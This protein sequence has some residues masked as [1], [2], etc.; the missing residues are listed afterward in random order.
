M[1]NRLQCFIPNLSTCAKLLF[2]LTGNI[3][4]CWEAEQEAAFMELKKV[5]VSAPVLALPQDSGKWKVEMD[6]SNLATGGVLSQQP[7]RTWRPVN[8]IYKALT[9]A[10]RNYDVYD[11]EF[12]TVIKV[13]REWRV[14]LIGTEETFEI[15]TD[16]AN[17]QYFQKPQK[18]KP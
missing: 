4:W 14:Y 9:S 8:Y 17:L 12:L 2:K 13:L 5:L 6:A 7:D 10:E 11:K 15:W 1:V 16:H 18:P 3:P